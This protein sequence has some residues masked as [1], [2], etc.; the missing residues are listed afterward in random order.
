MNR[1]SVVDVRSPEEFASG[2]VR[3]AHNIPLREIPL[4]LEEIRA[5]PKPI[6]LCSSSG[7]RSAM[8]ETYLHRKHIVSINAGSWED[9]S[10][11]M[12]RNRIAP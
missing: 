8:A 12:K 11:F 6:V 10:R 9:L 1:K 4:R 3:G 2:H 7:R 5:L